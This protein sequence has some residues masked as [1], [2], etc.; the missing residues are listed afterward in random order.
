MVATHHRGREALKIWAVKPSKYGE[1]ELK[2]VVRTK[3]IVISNYAKYQ[4]D[5]VKILIT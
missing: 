1:S 5:I 3:C 4:L 2:W